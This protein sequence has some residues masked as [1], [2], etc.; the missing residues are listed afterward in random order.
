ME[1]KI[2]RNIVAKKSNHQQKLNEIFTDVNLIEKS[3]F[4]AGW[5]IDQIDKLGST[6][7]KIVYAKEKEL[8]MNVDGY[9]LRTYAVDYTGTEFPLESSKFLE[10]KNVSFTQDRIF[11]KL[12]FSDNLPTKIARDLSNGFSL[13]RF[14]NGLAKNFG[15]KYKDVQIGFRLSDDAFIKQ[16]IFPVK[17]LKYKKNPKCCIIVM[18]NVA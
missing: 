7:F 8:K 11:I 2:K 5:F 12:D 18:K 3:L 17:F 15:A 1:N 16:P 6:S 14:E 13:K 10:M 9:G 4:S